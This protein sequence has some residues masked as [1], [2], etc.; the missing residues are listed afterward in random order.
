MTGWTAIFFAAKSGNREIFK[1]LLHRGA[2]TEI[3]VIVYII[4]D[5]GT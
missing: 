1:E 2:K 3:E 4:M 5:I